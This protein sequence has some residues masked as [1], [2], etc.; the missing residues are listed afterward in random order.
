MDRKSLFLQVL[1][2]VIVLNAATLVYGVY[3]MRQNQMALQTSSAAVEQLKVELE[4][5]Q[6][7]E[8]Y[9][10]SVGVYNAEGF[11]KAAELKQQTAGKQQMLLYISFKSP[12]CGH[13][14]KSINDRYGHIAGNQFVK[15]FTIQLKK[16]FPENR[17]LIGHIGGSIYTVLDCDAKGEPELEEKALQLKS[18]WQDVPWRFGNI[19]LEEPA[20]NIVA[21]DLPTGMKIKD[22]QKLLETRSSVIR[23]EA[24]FAYEFLPEDSVKQLR[25]KEGGQQ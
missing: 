14:L 5:S 1:F 6:R 21:A 4:E 17:Y 24:L 9:D 7:M 23:D 12:A 18:L 8:G 10:E 16:V 15:D 3:T 11:E 13:D 25:L 20:L 2:V 22:L 19:S